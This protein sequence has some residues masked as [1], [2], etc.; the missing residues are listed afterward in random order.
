MR[1]TV[2]DQ[3]QSAEKLIQESNLSGNDEETGHAHS[4]QLGEL[5]VGSRRQIDV[6]EHGHDAGATQTG[7]AQPSESE[8]IAVLDED[9]DVV[10][11]EDHRE[12]EGHQAAF[13]VQG[14][15][16]V[17]AGE[18]VVAEEDSPLPYLFEGQGAS[19]DLGNEDL[20]DHLDGGGVGC[21]TEEGF[22]VFFQTDVPNQVESPRYQAWDGKQLPGRATERNRFID[23]RSD[24]LGR[25]LD[26]RWKKGEKPARV[27]ARFRK[28]ENHIDPGRRV[29]GNDLHIGLGAKREPEEQEV[30]LAELVLYQDWRGIPR[31]RA[32]HQQ[33]ERDAGDKQ[34]SR[35]STVHRPASQSSRMYESR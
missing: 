10:L 17:E 35:I 7:K 30:E 4:R 1:S 28:A 16:E 21:G 5:R 29:T 20:I 13:Q 22:A 23:A 24:Q 6:E 32:F 19:G 18:V 12:V 11:I 9:G 34:R 25:H 8:V 31:L 26:S 33:A 15:G 2:R 3:E 14:N 27:R